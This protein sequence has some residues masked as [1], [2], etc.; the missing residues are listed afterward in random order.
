M[1]Q[2]SQNVFRGLQTG[3][4]FSLALACVWTVSAFAAAAWGNLP[5]V[6]TGS[7]LTATMWNDVTGQVNAL[8][9]AIGVSGGNVGIGTTAAPVAK[10]EVNGSAVIRGSLTTASNLNDVAIA[11]NMPNDM[12]FPANGNALGSVSD[13]MAIG[14]YYYQIYGCAGQNDFIG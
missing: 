9:S 13:P 3:F 14:T 1:S 8:A 2:F 10:L 6:S 5:T 7:G 4:G 11:S 12:S